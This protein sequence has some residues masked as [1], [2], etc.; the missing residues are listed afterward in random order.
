MKHAYSARNIGRSALWS[1]CNQS[2]GQLLVF[3]VFLVTARFVSKEAFG[4]MAT[5][6]FAV[7][8][9]RQIFIESIGTTFLSKQAP[10]ADDYNAGFFII[11]VGGALSA[12]ILFAFAGPIAEA[13][14]NSHM[15]TSLRWISLLLLTTGLSKM[16]EVWL[17][18]HLQFKSLAIR[19]VSSVCIGGAVGIFMA[20][21][22]CGI[23]SLIAQQI[24]TGVVGLVWLWSACEWR[25]ALRVRRNNVTSIIRYSRFVS[26]NSIAS[27]LSTQGDV[28]LSSFYLGPAA[29]GVYNAA[30]RL[31]TAAMLVISS[32]LNSVALPAQAAFADD[33]S[34]S[35]R[36]YLR[37]VG[38]T[39]IL[40]A[41]LFAGL[42][43]LSLDVIELLMG[44]KWLDAAPVLAIL[45]VTGFNRS[46]EQYSGNVLLIRHKAHWLTTIGFVNA[47]VNVGILFIFA[48]Y[49][50][51][52]LAAAFT[53]KTLLMSPV[54]TRIALRLLDLSASAYLRRIGPPLLVS[55]AM[56]AFIAM[57]RNALR[58]NAISNIAL[59][60]PLGAL[61][62]AA[63]LC[64][65][66]RDAFREGLAFLQKVTGKSA[67][68]QPPNL[69]DTP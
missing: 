62:Y 58:L 14:D 61:F 59:F 24:V 41:P 39:A 15:A 54:P 22:G 68:A 21:E 4:I 19:S 53:A 3:A 44:Q 30:K 29:T 20:I 51:I 37:C 12:L 60:V 64:L 55:L 7:E 9:F 2:L 43:A 65:F 63:L 25:P 45:A 8:L 69:A 33:V 42:A 35:Q 57:A 67:I 46:I 40:T 50:L 6:L 16:H 27:M 5:A 17:T 10:S 66:D 26:L 11:L 31:M 32:G 34:S 18:K 28:L 36:S 38:F 47:A 48:R 56:A 49:G 13:F 1:I 23:D 52:S